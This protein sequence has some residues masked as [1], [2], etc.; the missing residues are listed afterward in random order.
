M[1][2]NPEWSL[3]ISSSDVVATIGYCE[4]FSVTMN[5]L[6]FIMLIETS[7][8]YNVKHIAYSEQLN[9]CMLDIVKFYV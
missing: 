5:L 6:Y 8:L 9:V 4:F 3:L 2:S 7:V 1:I